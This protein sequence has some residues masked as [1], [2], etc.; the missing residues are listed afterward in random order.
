MRFTVRL[1]VR[2]KVKLR[3][4]VRVRV[5]VRVRIRVRVAVGIG[6]IHEVMGGLGPSPIRGLSLRLTHASGPIFHL[7]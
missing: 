5:R 4:R 7:G 3:D 1:R 2:V 6:S